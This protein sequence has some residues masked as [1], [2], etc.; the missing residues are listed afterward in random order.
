[1]RNRRVLNCIRGFSLPVVGLLVAS[2]WLLHSAR[3]DA[4]T[5]QSSRVRD[6]QEQRLATLR[7]LVEITTDHYKNGQASSDEL[8]SATRARDEAELELC[9]SSAERLPVLER[10]V[11]QAKMLE[12][13]DAKLVSNKLL[14]GTILLKAKADRLQQ[15]LRFKQE[16][17]R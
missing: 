11:Q 13:Q 8:W 4:Q 3:L 10:I 14:S 17:A 12:E 15:E 6:L 9:L 2:L 7:S 16:K 1:M 5:S